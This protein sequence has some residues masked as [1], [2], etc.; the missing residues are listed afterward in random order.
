MAQFL[1][2]I[3]LCL[4]VTLFAK[5]ATEDGVLVLTDKNF[6]EATK[7]HPYMMVEFYAPWCGHCKTLAPEYA[8]AAKKLE[9]DG[10]EAKLAKVDATAEKKLA[11]KFAIQGFPT[12]KFF[13][14][15]SPSEYEGGRTSKAIVDWVKKK[16]GPAATTLATVEELEHLKE[17]NDVFVVAVV[18]SLDG[19]D[20]KKVMEVASK[21]DSIAFAITADAAVAK[22]MTAEVG[23]MVLTK[24]FDELRN[25]F[26]IAGDDVDKLAT[27]IGTHAVRLVQVFSDETSE[28]IFGAPVQ[29][30]MLFFTDPKADHHQGVHDAFAGVAKDFR[31][32]VLMVNV[33]TKEDKVMEFFGYK[34]SD[35]PAAILADMSKEGSMKKFPFDGEMSS[36][37]AVKTFLRSVLDGKVKPTLKSEEADP[38]DTAKPVHVVKGST[39]HDMVI[40]NSKDVLLEFYAPWCGHCKQLAPVYDKLGKAFA[41]EDNIVIAKI[42]GTANEIDYPGVDVSGFPTILFFPGDDKSTAQVYNK[43]RTLADFATYLNNEAT[44]KPTTVDKKLLKAKLKDEDDGQSEPDDEYEDEEGEDDEDDEY[45]EDADDKEEL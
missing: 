41:K 1:L 6:D 38:S 44:N 19:D 43:G 9:K 8:K 4:V 11:K 10:A 22:A 13:R 7:A 40:N 36:A 32:E 37:D 5:I 2:T 17:A 16:S 18:D 39:F 15:G 29:K 3:A 26:K 33:P 21:S 35:A 12:L 31:G 45:D 23:T 34:A 25:E 20:A 30:H 28:A 27:D 24:D 14:S 42:D